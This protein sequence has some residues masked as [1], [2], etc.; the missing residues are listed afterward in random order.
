[1]LDTF[2]EASGSL[3]YFLRSSSLNPTG[4]DIIVFEQH[5]YVIKSMP[6]IKSDTGDA[7][8]RKEYFTVFMSFTWFMLS[9]EKAPF[10]NIYRK[11]IRV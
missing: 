7:K 4:S 6:G 5:Y 1:M 9:H 3:Q 8:T 2:V 11:K 10:Q